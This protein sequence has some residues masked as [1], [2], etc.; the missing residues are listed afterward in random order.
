MMAEYALAS[1]RHPH[2][3]LEKALR[4]QSPVIDCAEPAKGARDQR[5]IT[6]RLD[7][8]RVTRTII[9]IE[10]FRS[11]TRSLA[12]LLDIDYRSPVYIGVFETVGRKSWGVVFGVTAVLLAYGLLTKY[13]NKWRIGMLTTGVLNL[14]WGVSMVMTQETGRDV[15]SRS[16]DAPLTYLCS[17]LICLSMAARAYDPRSTS[18]AT[19]ITRQTAEQIVTG[20]VQLTVKSREED[21]VGRG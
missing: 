17:G 10:L 16:I 12:L 6:A 11:I 15:L 19:A 20:S 21:G 2:T 8:G 14:M 18:R 5:L 1:V 13:H 9:Y 3:K 4:E 7:A